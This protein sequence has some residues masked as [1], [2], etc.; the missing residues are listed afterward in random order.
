MNQKQNYPEDPV[1][2]HRISLYTG[3]AKAKVI[4]IRKSVVL[5]EVDAIVNAANESL[6]GGGG[7]DKAIHQ[8]AG[9]KLLKEC[10]T[11]DGCATGQAKLTKG[12]NLPAS[13][14]IHTVGPVYSSKEEDAINLANCYRNSLDIALQNDFD[15]IAFP[16]ISTGAYGYPLD[17]AAQVAYLA[18]TD[19]IEKN[20]QYKI[21]IYLVCYQKPELEAYKDILENFK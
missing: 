8:A 13:Y 3:P 19:W 21:K 6:L 4:A 20:I 5:M 11:L 7:V 14:I 2:M 1:E 17:K 10:R 9:P 15:S 18:I 16:N 12:Y